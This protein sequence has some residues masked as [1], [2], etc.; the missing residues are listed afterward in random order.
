MNIRSV[1]DLELAGRRVFIRVD[2][3]VP[4]QKPDDAPASGRR[5][6]LD[7]HITIADDSRIRAALPT[8]KHCIEE[9]A[10][11]VLASHLGRP[12][13][14]VDPALSLRPVAARLA[15]LIDQEVLVP[16]DCVGDGP[17]FLVNNLREGQ[18]VLL[19][20][21]R[22]HKEEV[23][24]E[25]NFSRQLA[26][27]CDVYINDAFGTAHR[28]HAS[29]FGITKHVQDKAAGRLLFK[30]IASLSR[31]LD[32]PDRPFVAILGGAKVKDKIPVIQNLLGK[33]DALLV[34]GA[35]AYTFLAA[36]DVDMGGS[37]VE[38]ERIAVA[39]QLLEKARQLGVDLLLPEDHVVVGSVEEIGPTA[40]PQTVAN[41][42]VPAGAVACDIGPKTRER[43]ANVIAGARTVFW[44][45]P[46]GIFEQEP[47]AAGT[48]AVARAVAHSG[49]FSVV[50]GGD[51]V[52]ALSR[53]GV[54]PFISHVSTGGGASLEFV[55]G[56][57]LPGIE[58]LEA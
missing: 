11:V 46:M 1:D 45:G 23:E 19:E 34:G 51:S 43:Y 4:L 24:C 3:N 9:G 18:V 38:P 30:E 16:D 53:A 14:Q 48:E 22:F 58:A 56:R 52:S 37:R 27:L 20:N 55:E 35:M 21:L 26:S 44:N 47:F 12:K 49:A 10:K 28:A 15:E 33:V 54:T 29:T 32:K 50:G 57:K 41:G 7:D 42:A 2:F 8:I 31:L 17:R 6:A 40:S 36:R 5:G 13:G 39:K 25:E